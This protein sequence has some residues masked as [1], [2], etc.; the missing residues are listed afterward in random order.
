MKLFI[1]VDPYR[2]HYGSS[3]LIVAAESLEDAKAQACTGK[4]YTYG[5]FERERIPL[6]PALLVEPNRVLDLPCAE[7]HEWSE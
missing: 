5:E 4:A 6:D 2:V 1:W 3:L 7:W